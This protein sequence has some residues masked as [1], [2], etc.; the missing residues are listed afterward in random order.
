MSRPGKRIA[1]ALASLCGMLAVFA[2]ISLWAGVSART[3]SKKMESFEWIRNDRARAKVNAAPAPGAIFRFA[4]FGDIQG[5]TA[6]LPRLIK[7]V[8]G[9]LPIAFIIQTGD[10]A[11]HADAGHY[12]VLLGAL[13]RS[14]LRHPLFVIPGN[15]DVFDDDDSLFRRYFG[16]TPLWF[17]YGDSLFILLD[18]SRGPFVDEQYDWLES[19]LKEQAT[20]GSHVFMFMHRQPI[21]WDGGGKQP[22]EH[23]Y[24]RLFRILDEYEVNY[25]FTGNWHGYHREVRDGTV[26]IVNGQ[27]GDFSHNDRLVPAYL[28]LVEVRDGA[29]T[30]RKITLSPSVGIM[31]K[32]HADDW[33][34]AHLG[35]LAVKNRSITFLIVLAAAA[36]CVCLSIIATKSRERTSGS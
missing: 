36:G 18:N 22:V 34:I 20:D 6:Q 10:A 19:V 15:H 31:L 11:A 32:C 7:A 14:G 12:N 30:D 17:E 3:V 21:N 2:M 8:D 35:E 1:I 16:A 4:V 29:V 13:A 23:Q 9:E 25:V 26:F 27:G 24:A 28:T 5:G 33:L